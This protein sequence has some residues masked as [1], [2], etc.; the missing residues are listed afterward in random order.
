MHREGRIEFAETVVLHYRLTLRPKQQRDV[1]LRQSGIRAAIDHGDGVDDRL[2]G[3]I[4]V[5]GVGNALLIIGSLR[6]IAEVDFGRQV[7]ELQ[8]VL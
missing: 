3:K 6:R 1:F 8:M 2:A 4:A 7:N 5:F